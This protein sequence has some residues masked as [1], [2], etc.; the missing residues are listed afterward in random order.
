MP[1]LVPRPF[2]FLRALGTRETTGKIPRARVSRVP[3]AGNE[4]SLCPDA[5]QIFSACAK[6][7]QRG[8]NWEPDCMY[9][10]EGGS[11][12]PVWPL[13]QLPWHSLV[14]PAGREGRVGAVGM[15]HSV[16]VQCLLLHG[17]SIPPHT[18]L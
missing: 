2:P 6:Y 18:S 12:H 5:L 7:L 3:N 11:D 14:E 9:G 4:A 10:G 16:D 13:L 1:S 8:F 15:W 17:A